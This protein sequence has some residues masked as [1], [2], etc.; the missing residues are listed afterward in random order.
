MLGFW[1]ELATAKIAQGSAV[2]VQQ[3]LSL[4]AIAGLQDLLWELAVGSRCPARH[5][6][7]GAGQAAKR[8]NA[9]VW[10]EMLLQ[11]LTD[12]QGQN[13]KSCHVLVLLRALL[14]HTSQHCQKSM[15]VAENLINA[16]SI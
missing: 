3:R 2:S 5:G 11:G 15:A 9:K 6:P 13:L 8:N 12:A 4:Q 7:A 10:D 14:L 16:G 1:N